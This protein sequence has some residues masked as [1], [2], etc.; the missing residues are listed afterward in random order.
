M[1][2]KEK[3]SGSGRRR[4]SDSEKREV[5]RA[6]KS[7]KGPREAFFQAQGVS[8]GAIYRWVQEAKEKKASKPLDGKRS[9]ADGRT[10]GGKAQDRVAARKEAVEAYLK[11]VRLSRILPR[12]GE[13]RTRRFRAGE[14]FTKSAV[15]R[16]WSQ[17][18]MEMAGQ[19]K[20]EAANAARPCSKRR[21][22]QFRKKTRV[23]V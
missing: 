13:C 9:K 6:F 1:G 21:S 10:T 2:K 12:C 20:S 4:F 19:E 23:L 7:H 11:A 5:V 15:Q 18:F 3:E 17:A 16:A 14:R 8:A 22:F